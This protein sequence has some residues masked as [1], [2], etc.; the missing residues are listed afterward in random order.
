LI[1]EL[2][3]RALT[4]TKGIHDAK[5]PFAAPITLAKELF[6]IGTERNCVHLELNIEGSGLNYQHGDHVGVWPSNAEIE[7]D[8]FLCV[9]G[10][11]SSERRDAVIGIESLDPALA[12][13]PF[14]VPTTYITVL[15]H[16]IDISAVAGR[17]IL[18]N[19]AKF[20]PT[21]EAQSFLRGI[22]SDKELYANI[23]GGGC[24]K[25]AEV[26][27]LAAG[28][29]IRARPTPENTTVWKIPFDMIVSNIP[30]LQPRYF[31][32]S[33]SPKLHPASIHIT[34]VVLKYQSVENPKTNVKWV[35]GVGSN[36][37]LNLKYAVNSEQPSLLS[38]APTAP[39]IPSTPSYA[40]AGP[41]GAYIQET[42]YKV[43][44][45]VRRSTF[46]L[47]TNPKSPIIM[48]GP[49]T[50]SILPQS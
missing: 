24:L 32:I 5:N 14:P 41:R 38:T 22:S 12:K 48:I 25:L 50:V 4:R 13:V 34:A 9:L 6:A 31:S 43:P 47:P 30:R 17:Q 18:G 1:G 11:G 45:H 7:V 2:S 21:D 44:V 36:F 40:I 15:R 16:Y 10:L 39:A 33:S 8:R 20:A 37:L 27:Q 26:L 19:L 23:V 28:D 42:I 3:A 35:F 46:R 29:D 49:G